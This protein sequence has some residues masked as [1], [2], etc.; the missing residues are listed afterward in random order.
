MGGG[1]F[2]C[3]CG[4]DS[5]GEGLLLGNTQRPLLGV[6]FITTVLSSL[7][8]GQPGSPGLKGESGDLG[9]QVTTLL[10]CTPVSVPQLSLPH[11]PPM[12]PNLTPSLLL[13]GPQRTSGTHRPSWQ[14]WEKGECPRGGW[15]LRGDR[16]CSVGDCAPACS[17]TSLVLP[18]PGRC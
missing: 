2:I 13:P 17:D 11:S 16:A 1:C 5:S 15:V 12:P 6:S 4:V 3:V 8:Q 18:G 7:S 9:P 14:S 10:H